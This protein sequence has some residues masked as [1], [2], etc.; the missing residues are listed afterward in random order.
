MAGMS[1]TVGVDRERAEPLWA[2]I[3]TDLRRRLAAG[4]FE[5]GFP[6]DSELVRTYGVSRHT[7]R[8]ACR[9]LQDEGVI[10]RS[11][12]R[13]S[14]VR[15]LALEQQLGSLYSVFGS[16][17]AQ[18]Y[19]QDSTVLA[20]ERC[21]DRAVAERLGLR[22]DAELV[23]LH[24]VRLAD[25]SPFAIDEVWLP[26]SIGEV[27]FDADLSHTALYTELEARLGVRPHSGVEHI[28]PALP[29]AAEADRLEVDIFQPVF[30]IERCTDS[31]GAPLEWRRTVVRGDV[32]RFS[33]QWSSQSGGLGFATTS[34]L[35]R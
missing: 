29:S 27:L 30:V 20:L 10:T 33:T 16:I 28:A 11:R 21:R 2:Q 17:E 12:G 23:Y 15:P 24:R 9:R 18:G 6:A 14:S 35:S 31:G 19:R 5:T 25:G 22:G 3:L 26:A 34:D 1:R 13:G 8:D 32:F 7:V 4:E